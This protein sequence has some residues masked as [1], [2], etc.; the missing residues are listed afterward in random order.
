[1]LRVGYRRSGRMRVNILA[2]V[3]VLAAGL[4]G[5]AMA[6]DAPPPAP[7]QDRPGRG[8]AAAF[9]G[10]GGQITAIEGSTI[11]LQTLSGE[12]AKVKIT[13]STR[14]M[15][16]RNKAKL[17]DFKV[18]DRVFAAGNQGTDGTWTA[19]M[20]GQRTGGS[21]R[22]GGVM[23]GARSGSQ[24]KP[25]DN[26]KSYILGEITKIDG[27]KLTVKKP[28]NT[29]QVIEVD[30]DTS[31]HNPRHESVTLPDI[32]TG[33]FVRGIGAV[34]NGVFVPKELI[35]GRPR[36]SRQGVSIAPPPGDAP[37]SAAPEPS[38]ESPANEKK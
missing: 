31:F 25:E 30:D 15:K 5:M 3:A 23:G 6:Q 37:Q 32:K 7:P 34:K 24:I 19:Q 33:E 36:R 11:T 10:V 21:P 14:V 20:L 4:S 26:G 8:M 29:E 1:M 16:D 12:T 35:A 38:N 13:S 18:G 2:A 17:T 28:N 22:G 27:T 9:H